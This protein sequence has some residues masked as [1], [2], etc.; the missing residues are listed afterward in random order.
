[1]SAIVI[2]RRL[3][4]G[5]RTRYKPCSLVSRVRVAIRW[6][7][8]RDT[9]T[10]THTHKWQKCKELSQAT[11]PPQS[12]TGVPVHNS[13]NSGLVL[14]NS[15]SWAKYS[16][17]HCTAPTNC[18]V[19]TRSPTLDHCGIMAQTVVLSFLFHVSS[20]APWWYRT[21]NH[22]VGSRRS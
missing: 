16:Q 18:G 3:I 8:I 4:P 17:E 20:F 7:H 13:G 21:P 1:M 12:K 15:W 22:Q 11:M 14:K 9:H 19:D 6:R 2:V 5:V 10:H